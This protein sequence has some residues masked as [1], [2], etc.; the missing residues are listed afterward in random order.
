MSRFQFPSIGG[1]PPQ[2]EIGGWGGH[3]LRMILF[4]RD[5][6]GTQRSCN[7]DYAVVTVAVVDS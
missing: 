6:L 4:S 1:V 3:S 5:I 2:N 7:R